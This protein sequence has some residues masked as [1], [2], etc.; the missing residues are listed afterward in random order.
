MEAHDE[1]CKWAKINRHIIATRLVDQLN[2]ECTQFLLD[3]THNNVVQLSEVRIV[4]ISNLEMMIHSSLSHDHCMQEQ[5]LRDAG[6]DEQEDD[7]AGVYFLHRKGAA[8]TDKGPV[9]IPGSRGAY[10]YLVLPNSNNNNTAKSGWSLAHG[11]GRRL[12]RNT[13]R[14]GGKAQHPNAKELLITD[15]QSR[16][17]CD[18]K[19]LLYEERPEAYKDAACVVADL[20]SSGLCQVIAVMKPILTYKMR[21]MYDHKKL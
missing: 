7:D 1:A 20:V 18:D 14:I 13:A 17:I 2:A 16:V 11:A 4:H 9:L 6:V 3:I 12:A 8:P 19:G 10:S 5:S 15:L 21:D